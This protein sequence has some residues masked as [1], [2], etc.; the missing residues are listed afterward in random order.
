MIRDLK[1][2]SER[3]VDRLDLDGA[4]RER[5]LEALTEN[6]HFCKIVELERGADNVQSRRRREISEDP[7]DDRDP[8]S[9]VEDISAL[10]EARRSLTDALKILG[11]EI[12]KD[13]VWDVPLGDHHVDLRHAR[14]G[15]CPACG[16]DYDLI[17]L[18]NR[19][20]DPSERE[21]VPVDDIDRAEAIGWVCYYCH[22]TVEEVVVDDSATFWSFVEEDS[23]NRLTETLADPDG[24]G[25]VEREHVEV[26]PLAE[27]V[28][29][30]LRAPSCVVD[31]CD[32]RAEAEFKSGDGWAPVCGI[33]ADER[34]DYGAE[35]RDLGGEQ[36]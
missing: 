14:E 36:A 28:L 27:D 18:G 7:D 10:T 32:D 6:D 16:I 5:A 8:Y 29:S 1:R 33:H 35:T 30:D 25:H 31:G 15:P 4:A 34:A 11:E 19:P 3:V 13:A 23:E 21:D 2:E 24:F 26:G 22:S 17:F 9:D 20:L 12:A